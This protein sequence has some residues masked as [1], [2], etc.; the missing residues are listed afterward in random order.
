MGQ[1]KKV[2]RCIRCGAALQTS[3]PKAKGYINPEVLENSEGVNSAVYC[4]ECYNTVIS[5]NARVQSSHDDAAIFSYFKKLPKNKMIV[6]YVVD[7]FA[8][9]GILDEDAVALAK[10]KDIVVVGTKKNVFGK[11]FNEKKIEE[12]INHGLEEYGIKPLRIFTVGKDQ[13]SIDQVIDTFKEKIID[14]EYK[15][16]DVFMVG[17][18][19]S[20]KTTLI[21]AFLKKY[22]NQSNENIS[23][24]WLNKNLK[25]TIIPLP[26]GNKFYELPDL[27]NNN[28]IV[29]KI[30]KPIQ[31]LVTPKTSITSHSAM[32]KGGE[33]VFVGS[34]AGFE[35]TEGEPTNYKYYCA[36]GVETKKVMAS[37]FNDAFKNNM[38]TKLVRPVSSN[39]ISMLDFEV[40]EFCFE[41]DDIFH[42]IAIEGLGFFVFKGVGQTIRICVPKGVYVGDSLGRI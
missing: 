23:L 18:K 15:G 19:G 11:D 38:I 33:S 9:S 36:P 13:K 21:S 6:L 20:G 14:G 7:L 4:D 30:E 42:E 10:N 35:V 37:K 28:S 1:G 31:N 40:F 26:D 39:F 2:L 29:S 34:I 12:C 3:D 27:S 24:E 25:A 8:F 41:K 5:I 16:R 22:S 32:L 17:R